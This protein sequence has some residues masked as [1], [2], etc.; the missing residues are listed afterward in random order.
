MEP[1]HRRRIQRPQAQRGSQVLNPKYCQGT[2][3]HAPVQRTARIAGIHSHRLI[4]FT[5][6]VG[7]APA[8]RYTIARASRNLETYCRKAQFGFAVS[9]SATALSKFPLA[10]CKAAR[11]LNASAKLGP[12]SMALL[13]LHNLASA[14]RQAPDQGLYI[15]RTERNRLAVTLRRKV[16]C[17]FPGV[18]VPEIQRHAGI[19]RAKFLSLLQIGDRGAAPPY[20][21]V[22]GRRR[23]RESQERA[24][25][26][27]PDQPARHLS[28]GALHGK[29]RGRRVTC[30][31]ALRILPA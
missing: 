20:R 7:I 9:R 11:L 21:S 15:F 12:S 29:L 16:D 4:E 22:L 26:R 19:I 27:R 5:K 6:C 24:Q 14:N 18:N 8:V 17:I 25:S 30:L 13:I 23:S 31:L 1:E 28:C 3:W 10:I 2:A